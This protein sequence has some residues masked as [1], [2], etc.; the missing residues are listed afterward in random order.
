MQ[1]VNKSK[2]QLQ[3]AGDCWQW[4]DQGRRRQ[5]GVGPN[6]Q[7][8][9]PL[10]RSALVMTQQ[11]PPRQARNRQGVPLAGTPREALHNRSPAAVASLR[12]R[13]SCAPA[14][15]VERLA[16]V[17]RAHCQLHPS[18]RQG[19]G[20]CRHLGWAALEGCWPSRWRLRRSP[21]PRGSGPQTGMGSPISARLPWRCGQGS[22]Q[23][24]PQ[25]FSRVLRRDLG[26]A[27]DSRGRQ[28]RCREVRLSSAAAK[29][30]TRLGNSGA[31]GR[32]F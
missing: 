20:G 3:R 26:E 18:Q 1:L 6:R 9:H 19:H 5:P 2:H 16:S 17:S 10:L 30:G 27:R 32:C 22:L 23:W 15:A 29:A 28:A 13:R 21:L 11:D 7:R 14:A 31:A 24:M 4:A 25:L 12:Q 8:Q